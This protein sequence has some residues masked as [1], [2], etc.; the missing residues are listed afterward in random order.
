M[1]LHKDVATQ[2]DD[3]HLVADRPLII[4]DADE[5][6]V[7]FAAGL[8]FY[9]QGQGLYFDISSFAITGNVRRQSD[10]SRRLTPL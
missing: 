8:E 7:Q 2:L 3:L 9:L 1:T 5:V 4:S 6:L 10:S